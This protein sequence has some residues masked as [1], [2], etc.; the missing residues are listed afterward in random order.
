M[1]TRT[2]IENAIDQY[3]QLAENY[4]RYAA[5]EFE[6]SDGDRQLGR[7][8]LDEARHLGFVIDVLRW[9]TCERNEFVKV[10]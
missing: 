7:G 4:T 3:R 1:R 9:V 8:Y 2:E 5:N 6:A 10:G